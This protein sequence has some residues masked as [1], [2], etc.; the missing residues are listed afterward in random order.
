MVIRHPKDSGPEKNPRGAYWETQYASQRRY[1]LVPFNINKYLYDYEA[2]GFT[3]YT[4]W[5]SRNWLW[6]G[7]GKYVPLRLN[8]TGRVEVYFMCAGVIIASVLHHLDV[9]LWKEKKWDLEPG[10][11]LPLRRPLMF[12]A[13][14]WMINIKLLPMLYYIGLFIEDKDLDTNVDLQQIAEGRLYRRF[15]IMQYARKM[16]YNLRR[17][18]RYDFLELSPSH[19]RE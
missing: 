17:D 14:H 10:A 6:E 12:R 4:L 13:Y 8:I 18:S 11:R 2:R 16:R 3:N 1:R 15:L 7:I 5:I 9:R 19:N